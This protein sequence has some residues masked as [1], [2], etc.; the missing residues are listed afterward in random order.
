MS[1]NASRTRRRKIAAVSQTSGI[2]ANVTSASLTSI[3]S[4]MPMMATRVKTSP[5]IGH[6]ARGEEL[7]QRLDVGG[8]PGHQPAD[9]VAVEVGD[10]EPLEMA[11]DLHPRSYITRWPTNAVST[12]PPYSTT[13]LEQQRRQVEPGEQAQQAQVLAR[14]G[15]VERPLGEPRADQGEPRLDQEQQHRPAASQ[16]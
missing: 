4:I 1:R 14:D 16:R 2:T 15:D 10:A 12:A 8:D 7:V 11:E 3:T 9:R 5:K 13:R 6:H